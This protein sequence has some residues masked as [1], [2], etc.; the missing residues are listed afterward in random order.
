MTSNSNENWR[1]CPTCGSPVLIDQATGQSEPCSTCAARA[2]P[3]G[4]GVGLLF[5][6][7]GMLAVAA[8]V[9]FC[10]RILYF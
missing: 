7:L 2:S 5:I 9:Y 8:L 6:V 4:L 3:W 1:P 10:I